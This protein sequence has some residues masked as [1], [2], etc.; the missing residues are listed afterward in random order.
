MNIL[1]RD[2]GTFMYK[3]N[4]YVTTYSQTI[5]MYCSFVMAL[6]PV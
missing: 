2:K 6:S 5:Q 1:S 4:V 3:P